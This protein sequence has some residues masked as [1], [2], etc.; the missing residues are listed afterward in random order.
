MHRLYSPLNKRITPIGELGASSNP[1]ANLSGRYLPLLKDPIVM[2]SLDKVASEITQREWTVEAASS[3][4]SDK[5]VAKFVFDCF[6]ELG[7][8]IDQESDS[9]QLLGGSNGI[10]ALLR[11]FLESTITGL[12][13]G[14][15]KWRL[16]DKEAIIPAEIKMRNPELLVMVPQDNGLIEPRYLSGN[17]RGGQLLPPRSMI[18]HRYWC[19]YHDSVYGYGLGDPLIDLVTYRNTQI[20][21]W[22]AF[23]DRFTLPTAIGKYPLTLPKEEVA[24]LEGGLRGLGRETAVVIPDGVEISWLKAEGG[25]DTFEKILNY[26]DTQISNIISGESTIGQQGGGGSRAR[27]SVADSLR[28]RK[29]KALSDFLCDTLNNTLIKWIVEL[30]FPAGTRRPKLVINFSDL[31]TAVDRSA[32]LSDVEKLS[33]IGWEVDPEWLSQQLGMPIKKIE[34][35]APKVNF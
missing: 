26:C 10:N 20:K 32:L 12:S 15:I 7:S 19:A 25:T 6:N 31:D 13:V 24:V 11:G 21:N 33:S 8:R 16:G 4:D 1:G 3:E 2:A 14:E 29:C 9:R 5:L 23:A 27:D 18:I 34:S 17:S 28:V 22:M 35:I 30:N